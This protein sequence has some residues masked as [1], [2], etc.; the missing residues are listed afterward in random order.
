MSVVV[1]MMSDK[2]GFM[3]AYDNNQ[4]AYLQKLGWRIC[5]E[6][7]PVKQEAPKEI[8]LVPTRFTVESEPEPVKRKPGRPKVTSWLKGV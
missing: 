3:H 4:I 5:E 1:K 8:P 7:A 2:H 6:K